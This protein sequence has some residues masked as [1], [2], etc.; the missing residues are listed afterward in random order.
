MEKIT[1][2][3]AKIYFK[4]IKI[5]KCVRERTIDFAHPVDRRN[6]DTLFCG[7]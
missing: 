5:L 4:P 7:L 3:R 1:F 6:T 2:R